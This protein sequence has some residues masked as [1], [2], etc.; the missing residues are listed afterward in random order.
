MKSD[1]WC[2]VDI[3]YFALEIKSIVVLETIV[4]RWLY[5]L[6]HRIF[7]VLD[8]VYGRNF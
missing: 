4:S 8:I 5:E 3:D 6:E 1:F 7:I 2:A